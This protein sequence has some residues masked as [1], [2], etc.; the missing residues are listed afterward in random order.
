MPTVGPMVAPSEFEPDSEL[1][2]EGSFQ[3]K[4]IIANNTAI[5]ELAEVRVPGLAGGAVPW[6]LEMPLPPG[7]YDLARRVERIRFKRL[8][9]TEPHPM[10]TIIA[11]THLE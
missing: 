4:I 3:Q 8:A 5:V 1:T 9:E 11:T 7:V 6:N 10:V 2:C